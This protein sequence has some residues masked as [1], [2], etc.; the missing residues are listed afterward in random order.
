MSA[1]QVICG[2]SVS[3]TTTLNEHVAVRPA[4]SLAVAV[5]SVVPTGNAVPEAWLV[6][7]VTPGQLSVAVTA[8]VT[9]AEH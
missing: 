9:T 7:T 6:A 3:F 8:Y 1:G 2:L 4:A 5:T